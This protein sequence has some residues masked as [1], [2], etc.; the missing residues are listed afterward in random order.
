MKPDLCRRV[1]LALFSLL[2]LLAP[3]AARAALQ[4][5]DFKQW[6]LLAVQDEGRRKPL[7]TFAHDALLRITGGSFMGMDVYKDTAG[8]VWRPNDFV[9]S[10]LSADG[11]DWKKEPLVLV[12]YRPLVQ[13]LGLDEEKRHFSYGELSGLPAFAALVQDIR[14]LRTGGRDVQ[15]TR[16]QQEV[17]NVVGRLELFDRLLNHDLAIIPPPGGAAGIGK[18]WLSGARETGAAYGEAQLAPIAQHFNDTL[19]AYR[20]GDSY[21]FGSQARGLR[22]ELRALNPVVYPG[23]PVLSNEYTY[24]HLGAFPWAAILYCSAAILLAVGGAGLTVLR[25]A[26]RWNGLG[27]GLVGLALHA[28]GIVLRCIIAGRPPVTNMYEVMIWVAFVVAALGFAFYARYRGTTFLLAALPVGCLVL[29]LVQNLPVVFSGAIEP[30]QPVLRS[31]FWLWT[32]V[33]LEVASYGAFTL[34]MAFGHILL[35]RYIL[36]PV[37]ARADSVLHFW[38]YRVLQLGVLLITVGTILGAVWANYSW[39]RFWGWDPKETWACITLLVYIVAIHGRIAGWWGQFGMAVASV[40]CFAAVV[41]ASYGVNY[42]LGKGL[43]SYG[44]GVGGEGY[45]VGFLV[46]D[47][48]FLAAACWRQAQGRR[49]TAGSALSAL[50][51]REQGITAPSSRGEVLS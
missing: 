16:E 44:R 12:N 22:E 48:L 3:A 30:L 31:N 47:A 4:E 26:L 41:M 27:L 17:E 51:R 5:E 9:L 11:H 50:E 1:L 13:R 19:D 8:R 14:A 10:I 46:L 43:H 35:A 20:T 37:A 23:D 2:V 38:L 49:A 32:H 34:G 45:V 39:G 24:N 21:K 25:R 28:T 33:P 29:L 36:N 18:A 6:G 7:D 40:V 15:P 42:V